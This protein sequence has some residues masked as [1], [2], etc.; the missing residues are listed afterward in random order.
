VIADG[1]GRKVL[2]PFYLGIEV[3]DPALEP[4][5][6]ES[7]ERLNKHLVGVKGIIEANIL[8][9]E[10]AGRGAHA[11]KWYYMRRFIEGPVLDADPRFR[12]FW[13]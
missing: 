5:F 9:L 6:L 8:A 2:N 1:F 7:F 3:T 11:E 12:P 13:K 4:A 10:A